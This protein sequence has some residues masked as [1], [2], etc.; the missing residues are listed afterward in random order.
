VIS[1]KFD[2]GVSS[3]VTYSD[4]YVTHAT[5][6]LSSARDS[7][8]A[9]INSINS[10]IESRSDSFRDKALQARMVA[11][12]KINAYIKNRPIIRLTGVFDIPPLNFKGNNKLGIQVT[13]VGNQPISMWFG[14][15]FIDVNNKSYLY[16]Q[17][18]SSISVVNPGDTVM[19]ESNI[20]FDQLFPSGSPGNLRARLIPNRSGS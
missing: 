12:D 3:L 15:R 13:N 4:K 19:I 10:I 1:K 2:D 11:S 17:T 5:D 14:W 16:N 7:V 6:E 9:K 20:P 18:P 8:T